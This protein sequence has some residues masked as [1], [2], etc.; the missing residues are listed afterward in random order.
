[1]AT[2]DQ[3][4]TIGRLQRWLPT[5]WFP[6][7]IGTRIYATLAGFASPFQAV[8]AQIAYTKLQ[9]RLGTVTD[10][11]ADLASFDY[12]GNR[13]PRIA[14]ESDAAY[15]AR[16]KAN[17]FLKA[18]TRAAVL[19][20]VESVT[21]YPAR[22]IEPW[23]PN[24]TFVWG[25]SFWGVDTAANPGNWSDGNQRYNGLIVC[26]LPA[27]GQGTGSRF[28]WGNFF[29]ATGPTNAVASGSW[30]TTFIASTAIGLIYSAINRT[31]VFGTQVWVQI[32][33]PGSI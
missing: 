8:F 29:W 2:G 25:K 11:F 13:L 22:A 16:I 1:M 31:K 17:I 24:D 21:G 5:R 23:Q 7:S 32:R 26:S 18:N 30:W 28:G 6:T 3:L 15:V 4:D 10:G 9:T 12:L 33:P 27:D 20:A 19:A 14:G